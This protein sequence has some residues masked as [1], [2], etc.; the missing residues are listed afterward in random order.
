M[1]QVIESA[2]DSGDGVYI[3]GRD[4]TTLITSLK[5]M[6]FKYFRPT[7]RKVNT[8]QKGPAYEN[9][10]STENLADLIDASDILTN[11]SVEQH[12]A[13]IKFDDLGHS[14]LQESGLTSGH[15]ILENSFSDQLAGHD[16]I[17]GSAGKQNESQFGEDGARTAGEFGKGMAGNDDKYGGRSLEDA[18]SA[19]A[20]GTVRYNALQRQ[21]KE[22][23]EACNTNAKDQMECL[24][25][26]AENQLNEANDRPTKPLPPKCTGEDNSAPANDSGRPAP[27][28]NN[29]GEGGFMTSK[30]QDQLSNGLNNVKDHITNPNG[31]DL[32]N[33]YLTDADL[34]QMEAD[35]RNAKDP[36]TNWGDDTYNNFMGAVEM[37]IGEIS[38]KAPCTNWGDNDTSNSD[39]VVD[40]LFTVPNDF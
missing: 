5:S 29:G 23:P 14:I 19:N 39:N 6:S 11:N 16:S 20:Y 33:N 8:T 32:G 9:T 10:T 38:L 35:L 37:N 18:V 27:D 17:L 30:L 7:L 28:D 15:S 25:K 4:P 12:L 26:E 40:T 13:D 31:D 22:N 34:I 1:T 36:A 21:C 24:A 2:G 3:G